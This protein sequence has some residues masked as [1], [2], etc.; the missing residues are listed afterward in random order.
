MVM[1]WIW[2]GMILFSLLASLVLGN[3]SA[4]SAAIPKG[5]QAG[6]ELAVSIAGSLCLWSGVGKLMEA[7]GAT[8]LLSRCFRPLL[9]KI[10][11]SFRKD[12]VLAGFLSSNVCAYF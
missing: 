3:G 1:S 10:F 4:L 12:P 8:G 9:G 2:T 7:A 11:P 6:L 5:A